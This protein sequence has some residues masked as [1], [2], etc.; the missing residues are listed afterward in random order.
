MNNTATITSDCTISSASNIRWT[1]G[2][3]S[4]TLDLEATTDVLFDNLNLDTTDTSSAIT[5]GPVNG[6]CIR[7][8]F[9]N[10]TISSAGTSGFT[11]W[12]FFVRPDTSVGGWPTPHHTDLI[13]ANCDFSTVNY[14]GARIMSVERLVIVDSVCID[15]GGGT[16]IRQHH[17]SNNVFMENVISE[18]MQTTLVSGDP[19]PAVTN[20]TANNIH[21]YNTAN[22][23]FF[24]SLA[25]ANTGTITDS[26]LHFTGSPTS[27]IISPY[28]DGSGNVSVGWNGLM[29]S[30]DWTMGGALPAKT[31]QTDFGADH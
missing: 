30:V 2:D 13:I 15:N 4:G 8:A 11:G 3:L 17:G 14:Q 12:G 16:G 5:V 10:L 27:P 9:I 31:A 28:T 26:T 25:A 20:L 29:S 18:N 1:G 6:A 22:Q 21:A 19:Q 7:T 24:L 23:L